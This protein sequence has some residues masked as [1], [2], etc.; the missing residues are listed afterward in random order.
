VKLRFQ[1]FEK[2][3]IYW[4]VFK[5]S[6]FVCIFNCLVM[7]LQKPKLVASSKNVQILSCDWRFAL[8]LC[9]AGRGSDGSCGMG[10]SEVH[11]LGVGVG[12]AIRL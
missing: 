1:L 9:E 3:F 5:L 4:V 6:F 12:V 2:L 11:V 10:Q 7:A 8:L